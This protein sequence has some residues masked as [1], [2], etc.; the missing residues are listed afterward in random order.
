MSVETEPLHRK[1]GPLQL[2][3]VTSLLLLAM[4][5]YGPLAVKSWCYPMLSIIWYGWSNSM[6]SLKANSC[7]SCT[8]CTALFFHCANFIG[9]RLKLLRFRAESFP[10]SNLLSGCKQFRCDLK[11]PLISGECC[12]MTRPRACSW[13][14]VQGG[15]SA[16]VFGNSYP[17][18]VYT[19]LLYI[20][21]NV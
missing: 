12:V 2:I 14:G 13:Y 9:D 10:R 15:E 18:G 19:L 17:Q 8:Q 6:D 5:R 1:L 7:R 20:S 3:F 11:R 21:L 16:P 4:A